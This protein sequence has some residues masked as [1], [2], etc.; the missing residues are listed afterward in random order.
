LIYLMGKVQLAV[1]A[2]FLVSGSV[3]AAPRDANNI[4]TI[5]AQNKGWYAAGV[6]ASK[7][8]ELPMHIGLAF[9]HRESSFVAKAKP[10]RKK[11]L[12]IVPW[13]RSSS[14]Y[15]YAQA[16]DEAWKDY[17]KDTGRRF[18]QRDDFADA[19]DFIGWYNDR[20]HKLLK[21]R[22]NDAYRLYLAYYNGH[23]GYS[24][25]RWRKSNTIKG[26]AKKAAAQ[27]SLYKKQ[28]RSCRG[29]SKKRSWFG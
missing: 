20:S 21:L 6:K 13:R 3:N 11:V 1:L 8:W 27:A 19:L 12:G 4:C 28:L 22:K 17:K 15:G 26:Y 10:P 7:R 18:V 24:Q 9:I 16:T 25:G 14:A 2:L 29:K 5:L 23:T